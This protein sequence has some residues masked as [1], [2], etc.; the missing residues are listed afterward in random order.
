MR[1]ESSLY[2]HGLSRKEDGADTVS[3]QCESGDDERIAEINPKLMQI[4]S[5]PM[6]RREQAVDQQLQEGDA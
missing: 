2:H 4:E 5:E 1:C 6:I 3:F